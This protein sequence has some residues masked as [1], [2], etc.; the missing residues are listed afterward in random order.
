[1]AIGMGAILCERFFQSAQAW[2]NRP[3]MV[4]FGPRGRTTTTFAEMLE[5]IRNVAFQPRSRGVERE[6]RVA[7]IGAIARDFHRHGLTTCNQ[8]KDRAGAMKCAQH[9][10]VTD[11]PQRL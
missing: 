4:M 1:M 2:P 9:L 10:L 11:Q 6:T 8:S 5:T 3:A 7:R